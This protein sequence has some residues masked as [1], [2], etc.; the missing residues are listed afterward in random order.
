MY[1]ILRRI[2]TWILP[3]LIKKADKYVPILLDN[4]IQK[5][6]NKREE[7]DTKMAT[8]KILVETDATI[9]VAIAGAN[10]S[11]LIGSVKMDYTTQN[12]GTVEKSGFTNGVE[13]TFTATKTG[14]TPNSCK[15]IASEDG[16]M[17]GVIKLVSN[18]DRAVKTAQEK[19]A[20]A[21]VTPTEKVAD[22]V[23]KVAEAA[24]SI[25]TIVD[26]KS[27]YKSIESD[28]K[29]AMAAIKTAM[30]AGATAEVQVKS[31]EFIS[32]TKTKLTD[33]IHWYV[34]QRSKLN[35]IKNFKEWLE[36][37]SM[38]GGLFFLRASVATFVG[39]ILTWVEDKLGEN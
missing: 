17:T 3:Y 25:T 8:I 26:A 9:P 19:A 4:L 12:D 23:A 29:T 33:S 39:E 15:V 20:V 5:I 1:E 35:V 14:Y 10:V 32:N 18:I 28:T 11:V 30:I 24:T 36:Y 21:T 37:S 22:V 13:Y 6:L 2:I 16:E 31:T 7:S 38:I 34:A 27:A